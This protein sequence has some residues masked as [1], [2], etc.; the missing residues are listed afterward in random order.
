MPS[1]FR[2]ELIEGIVH[3]PS[4]LKAKHGGPHAKAMV[5]AGFYES[6]TP[7]TLAFDNTTHILGEDS[8]PQPDVSLLIVGGQTK[9]NE[10]EY[11]V[12]APELVV[13]VASSSVAIDLH[14]KKRDYERHGVQEYVVVIVREHTVI[15]FIRNTDGLFVEMPADADQIHRSRKFPGLWLDG[16]ALLRGD[17]TRVLE[18][19]SQGIA[20]AEHTAFCAELAARLPK[21]AG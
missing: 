18:V 1:A 15:W 3:V 7:G 10:D 9:E 21:A 13:E 19:L 17:T 5:W 14:A 11:I 20:T 12:G 6:R 8:E 2:A 4:P 16:A